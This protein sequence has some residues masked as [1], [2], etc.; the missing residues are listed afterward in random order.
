LTGQ[1]PY[2]VLMDFEMF[3][4]EFHDIP[5]CLALLAPGANVHY[6]VSRFFLEFAWFKHFRPASPCANPHPELHFAFVFRLRLRWWWWWFGLIFLKAYTMHPEMTY[7]YGR[8]MTASIG[9][10][11]PQ[12]R[13]SKPSLEKIMANG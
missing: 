1:Y 11:I 2:T 5:V 8:C 12:T 3:G 7:Q 9:T 4:Q 10:N 13:M 6:Q